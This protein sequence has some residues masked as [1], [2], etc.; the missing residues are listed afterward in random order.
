MTWS[1]F[2]SCRMN[3]PQESPAAAHQVLGLERPIVARLAGPGV[4]QGGEG[5]GC[6][7]A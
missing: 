5:E 3:D 6:R 4:A 7:F 2:G 1:Y